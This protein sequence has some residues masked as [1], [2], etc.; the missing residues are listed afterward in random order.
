M[1]FFSPGSRLGMVINAIIG[2]YGLTFIT[3]GI[4]TLILYVLLQLRLIH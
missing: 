4:F 1:P 2:A 3:I